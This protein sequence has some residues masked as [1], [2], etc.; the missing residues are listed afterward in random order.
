MK[1][2]P[3]GTSLIVRPFRERRTLD[4]GIMLPDSAKGMDMI[5][6]AEVLEVGPG[7]YSI[8]QD[9]TTPLPVKVGDII[10]LPPDFKCRPLEFS[11]VVMAGGNVNFPKS[12]LTDISMVMG[13][14]KF[15]SDDERDQFVRGRDADLSPPL[16]FALSGNGVST[17]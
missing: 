1:L 7:W 3:F 17:E 2:I 14:M 13:S 15:D 10:A 8:Q 4:S 12:A 9:K 6:Y 11:S 5:I 16:R